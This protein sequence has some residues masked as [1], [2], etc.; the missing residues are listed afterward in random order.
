MTGI[1]LA[2]IQRIEME[3]NVHLP[4]A[5][6]AAVANEAKTVAG[7]IRADEVQVKPV[8][9]L[10]TDWLARD[11][12]AG[13]VGPS[14]S[15][16]TFV[17]VAWAC[18]VA[19]GA[20]WTGCEVKRG[21][22]F[23]LA[24]EGRNGL[25]KRI[26][27]WS[28]HTGVSIEGAPLY[29]ASKL[30][31]LDQLTTVTIM[32]EID[33]LADQLPAGTAPALIVIDTVAR[34]ITGDEN[35]SEHMGVLIECSD[36]MRERFPGCTV[37]LVHHTG[38]GDSGRARGSSAFYAALDSEALAKPLKSG[39]IQ[40]HATKCKDWAPPA[41]AQFRRQSVAITV[42]GLED[43]T[44]TLVL[45]K[46]EIVS[47]HDQIAKHNKMVEQV[48]AL[49]ASGT[50]IRKIAEETGLSK[51][52]VDRLLKDQSPALPAWEVGFHD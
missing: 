36:W 8:D 27:G 28:K 38:H 32:A 29:L 11:A 30:P 15:C 7:F 14:G 24:G 46:T 51:S 21:A 10:V 35:S 1:T 18:S 45:V 39:D 37:L 40:L 12:L 9:W 6:A 4:D 31:R 26:E 44:S 25:R 33:A 42:P 17:A 43:P 23:I 41:P 22:V 34:A 13:L 19:T 3:R 52:K 49:K 47:V 5:R 48:I 2:D 20:P 16:K 50:P